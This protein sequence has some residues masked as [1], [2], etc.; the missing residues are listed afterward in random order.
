MQ[1]PGCHR[2]ARRTNALVHHVELRAGRVAEHTYTADLRISSL[3]NVSG[4]VGVVKCS[5]TN[6]E[7]ENQLV[8]FGRVLLERAQAKLHVR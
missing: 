3:I 2:Q 1:N 8:E 6:V 5:G 7:S 4:V